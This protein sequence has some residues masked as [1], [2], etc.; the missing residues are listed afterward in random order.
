MVTIASEFVVGNQGLGY[1]IFNSRQLFQIKRTYVGIVWVALLG[2]ALS[3]M[4]A[5]IGRRESGLALFAIAA[6]LALF[7]FKHHVTDA[8]ALDF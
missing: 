8:L 2:V 3:T 1:L 4:V 5:W 7:W 6:L